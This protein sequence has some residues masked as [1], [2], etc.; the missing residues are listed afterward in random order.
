MTL[1]CHSTLQYI[2]TC[3]HTCAHTKHTYVCTCIPAYVHTYVHYCMLR[4]NT[5]LYTHLYTTLRCIAIHYTALRCLTLHTHLA[6]LCFASGMNPPGVPCLLKRSR[7]NFQSSRTAC[8]KRKISTPGLNFIVGLNC[9]CVTNWLTSWAARVLSSNLLVGTRLCFE[10]CWCICY[11]CVY[12]Y[13]YIS[14]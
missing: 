9:R 5:P 12:I 3:I 10:S 13:I 4:D 11:R 7:I 8:S 1:Q 6:G 14:D 2:H